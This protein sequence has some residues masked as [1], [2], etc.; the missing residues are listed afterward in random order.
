MMNLHDLLQRGNID[1]QSVLVL[2][3]TSKKLPKLKEPLLSLAE[4]EPD[5]FNAYQQHQNDPVEGEMTQAKYVAAFIGHEGKKALF[6]G[7]Y[8]VRG[9][10]TIILKEFWDIPAN[11]KL[12]DKYGMTVSRSSMRWFDLALTDFYFHLKGKLAIGWPRGERRWD[13]WARKWAKEMPILFPDDGELDTRVQA[14]ELEQGVIAAIEKRPGRGQ[15][16]LRDKEVRPRIEQYAMEAAKRYFESLQFAWEDHSKSQSYD[17]YCKRGTEALYIE[18]KGTTTDGR[19]VILTD[20][21]VEFARRHRHQ[22]GLFIFHSI[23]VSEAGGQFVLTGGEKTSIL[24][25]DMDHGCL[26]PLSFTY[27]IPMEFG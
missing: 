27:E 21:E 10:K 13:R 19:V 14:D 26:K 23:E 3:H 24:S 5:V 2:R 4:N 16:F 22:M 6:A 8:S 17:L 1:P 7:L 25:W 9:F 11:A 20:G 18:V 12:R 15:G